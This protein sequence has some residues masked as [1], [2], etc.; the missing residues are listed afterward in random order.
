MDR[1]DERG[2]SQEGIEDGFVTAPQRYDLADQYPG[3][4]AEL[5]AEAMRIAADTY[6]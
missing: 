1:G 2:N 3:R 4:V 5:H 6:R